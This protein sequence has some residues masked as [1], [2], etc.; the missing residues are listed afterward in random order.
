MA[1]VPPT[2]GQGMT[3]LPSGLQFAVVKQGTGSPPPAGSTVKVH[4]TGW[5]TGAAGKP[6]AQFFDT[7]ARGTPQEYTLTRDPLAGLSQQS[8]I[9]TKPPLIEGLALALLDMKPGETRKLIVPSN[10]AYGDRGYPPLVQARSDL[11]FDVEL[12]SFTPP[13]AAAPSA[14]P[15]PAP[16]K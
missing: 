7:R 6:P 1:A 14:P 11:S 8:S 3:S 4:L 5:V 9:G 15:A 13:A 16:V 2:P 10:L 12:V